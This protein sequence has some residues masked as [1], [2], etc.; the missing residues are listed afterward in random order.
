MKNDRRIDRELKSATSVTPA[1]IRSEINAA[2]K[3]IRRD[4]E[5]GDLLGALLSA[6]NL[7][8]PLLW[9]GTRSV[10]RKEAVGWKEVCDYCWACVAVYER[11]GVRSSLGAGVLAPALLLRLSVE[12]GTLKLRKIREA[13]DARLTRLKGEERE[14]VRLAFFASFLAELMVT[15]KAKPRG[16]KG[17]LY[18]LSLRATGDIPEKLLLEVCEFHLEN[19]GATD[20][21][22]VEF[23]GFELI[24]V[25]WFALAR[26][27]KERGLDTP[28]P[29]HA[30]FATPLA[31]LPSD[32]K[33]DPAD[34]ALLKRIDTIAK[35]KEA[36]K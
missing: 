3:S 2:E 14:E 25:W 24:P 33:Y 8:R 21:E 5:S 7:A 29:D 31:E 35:S 4:L 18:D 26:A 28:R 15:G 6:E 1:K 23:V 22:G 10:A 36:A 13:L 32:F 27:R 34:N 11:V 20:A 30:L 12:G 9:R 19:T 16:P 17:V